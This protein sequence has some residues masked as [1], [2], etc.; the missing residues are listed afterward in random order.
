MNSCGRKGA[1][2]NAR[3]VICTLAKWRQRMDSR[4]S[5]DQLLPTRPRGCAPILASSINKTKA[6]WRFGLVSSSGS[7]LQ[8]L[9]RR[10]TPRSPKWA[11]S[12]SARAWALNPPCPTQRGP[13]TIITPSLR[14]SSR[15]WR[16]NPPYFFFQHAFRQ[17]NVS[18]ALQTVSTYLSP[19]H[20]AQQVHKTGSFF[21]CRLRWFRHYHPCRNTKPITPLSTRPSLPTRQLPAATHII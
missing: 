18:P 17:H 4:C 14:N 5:V 20:V 1:R 10:T 2:R 8:G 7:A 21:S 9:M 3:R 12:K 6:S 11:R 16:V 15:S 19:R 13:P